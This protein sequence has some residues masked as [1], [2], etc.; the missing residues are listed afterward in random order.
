MSTRS[1]PHPG[2]NFEY[3][4]WLFTRISGVALILLAI[5]GAFGAMIMGA[6]NQL[7][8]PSLLRWTYFPNPNHVINS[9][10]PDLTAGWISAW[11]QSLQIT[12]L[13]FGVTHG[14]NGL[15]NVIEDYVHKGSLQTV[16]RVVVLVLWAFFMVIGIM[17]VLTN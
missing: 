8:L 13:A 6:R 14:M 12:L 3:V 7:D 2:V 16:L 1:V 15:R 9:N 5:V 4:M 17:I 11:W 10:I